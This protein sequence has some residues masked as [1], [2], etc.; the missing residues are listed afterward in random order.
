VAKPNYQQIRK[1]REAARKVRQMEKLARKMA[2]AADP[3][4]TP[5]TDALVEGTPKPV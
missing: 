4:N 2:R 5:A 3:V 1:Q